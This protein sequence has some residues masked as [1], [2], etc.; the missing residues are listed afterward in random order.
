MATIFNLV[1]TNALYKINPVLEADELESRIIYASPKLKT[2]I[3]NDLPKAVSFTQRADTPYEQFGAL[4]DDFAAGV[5]L[6]VGP[7]FHALYP[8]EN[9]TWE[10]KTV[11]VRVFGWFY[12]KDVFIGYQLLEMY[13]AKKYDGVVRN[14]SDLTV[15]FRDN[16]PLDPPKFVPGDDPNAVVTGYYIPR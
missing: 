16:L 7:Q 2:Q 1:K 15:R 4:V 3:E 11:D 14:V 8:R 6:A 5:P 10:L 9:H 13:L 12:R